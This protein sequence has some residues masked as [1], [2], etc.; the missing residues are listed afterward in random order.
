MHNQNEPATI[1]ASIYHPPNLKRAVCDQTIDYMIST[2]SDLASNHPNAKFLIYGD[3][4]YL[5][6]TPFEDVVSLTQ[7]VWFSTRGQNKLDLVYTDITEYS[8]DPHKTCQSAPNVGRSDHSSI[9]ISTSFSPKPKYET[10]QRRVVTE[11]SKIEVTN[12]LHLQ[13]WDAV[14]N[15]SDPNDKASLFQQTVANIV[16]EHCP[17]RSIRVPVGKTPIT[18]PLITKLRRAKKSAFR[19]KCPSWKFLSALFKSKLQ[20][21]QQTRA[22]DNINSIA[23]GSKAWWNGVKEVTGERKTDNNTE[24]VNVD[25]SWLTS[26]EFCDQINNHYL[27][28]GEGTTLDFPNLDRK[29]VV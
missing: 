21:L 13:S 28:L 18:T 6:M 2:V 23:K 29:S 17:V 26:Q 5:D 1:Y 8:E 12:K 10:I 24:Y 7:L 22:E 3:F 25:N 19:K 14:L 11:K 16:D 9:E 20:E 4:N 27:S 15:T